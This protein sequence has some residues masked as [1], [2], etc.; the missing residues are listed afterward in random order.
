MALR[1][2]SFEVRPSVI[3][4]DTADVYLHRT[5][6]ILRN[7][8]LNP[9]V[10]M[11]FACSRSAVLCGAMEVK[12]VL[13]KVTSEGNR[14][15]WAVEE[16]A[17]VDEGEVCLQV[18]APYSSF[19]LYET[20]ICGILAHSTAWATAA[21]EV[22]RA[23]ENVPVICVGA[24]SVHPSVAPVMDYAAVVGGCA[25]GST[26]L[27]TRLANTQPIATVSGALVQLMGSAVKAID[28]FDRAVAP[29]VARVA[30][31]DPRKD[32]VA[33]SVEV[34]RAMKDRLSAVRLAR[35]PGGVSVQADVVREVRQRL[36]AV[37]A[38]KV[39]I[40][41]SGRMSPERI[42]TLLDE[43]AP[44]DT[45]HDTGYIAAASPVPFWPNIRS[46]SERPIPQ[47]TEPPPPNPRLLRIL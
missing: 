38:K 16:G 27:G 23:A 30:Y 22:V 5:Q 3:T 43:G 13:G 17:E 21:T 37:G 44:V 36:D 42:R 24:H 9:R 6:R 10:T 2:P 18:K 8:G 40:V 28:A 45:F 14:E 15:V 46:I 19:G 39:M 31:V 25:S 34:A 32:V 4:G 33:Q 29:D 47:E 35:V 26:V 12:A 41:L 7:E 20:A 1:N 11:E